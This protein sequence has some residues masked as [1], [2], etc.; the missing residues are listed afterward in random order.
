[1]NKVNALESPD[2]NPKEMLWK[3]LKQLLLGVKL[4][5]ESK[6]SHTL[7]NHTYIILNHFL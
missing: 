6:G 5:N 7:A 3:D 2:V 4:H 1:M